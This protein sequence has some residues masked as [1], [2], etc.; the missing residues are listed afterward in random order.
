MSPK[1]LLSALIVILAWGVNFV[2][3]KVGLHGVPPHASWRVA[4]HAGRFPGGVLR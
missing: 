4:L 2:V 3:I 1:D